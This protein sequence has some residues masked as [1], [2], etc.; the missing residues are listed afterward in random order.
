M[1]A[2]F[3]RHVLETAVL[4]AVSFSAWGQVAPPTAGTVQDTLPRRSPPQLE[5]A[6]PV[7]EPAASRQRADD[8]GP[9]VTVK[10][11]TISGETAFDE[12][13]LQAELADLIGKPLTMNDIFAAADRLTAYYRARGYGLASVV[14]PAQ[15]VAGGVVNLE[16][17]E[18]R[19]GQV[20]VEGRHSYDFGR[21]EAYSLQDE[22][23]LYRSAAMERTMLLLNDIPGLDARAIIQPG[24]KF[25]T[26]DV[27]LRV[28]EDRQEYRVTLDNYGREELGEVRL[29]G[30]ADFNNPFG[31]GDQLAVDLMY[32]QDGLLTYGSLAYNFPLASN[33]SRLAISANYA[34]YEVG[35]GDF[36]LLDISGDT[37]NF[38]VDYSYPWLRS[39]SNNL[40]LTAGVSR[41]AAETL[42]FNNAIPF[43]ETEL[44]LLEAGLF[45][46]TIYANNS[47]LSV[48]TLFSGNFKSREP[49]AADPQTDAQKAKLR[50]DASYTLPFGR[51][52]FTSRAA[53]VYSPDPLV[54]TQKYSLG[55]PF[56]VRG[57]AP[58]QVRGDK[59]LELSLEL[60]RYFPLWTGA[61]GAASVFVDG[62]TVSRYPAIAAVADDK[63]SL[64]SA[65]LGFR[66]DTNSWYKFTVY[67]ATPIGN[68]VNPLDPTLDFDDQFWLVANATF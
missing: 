2:S 32:T 45:W 65:G 47:S 64:A 46:N 38:R 20:R 35:G 63:D 18:G 48:F 43:N 58:A 39:R 16:V 52:A 8:D 67:W 50:V 36:A 59:G 30:E 29:L 10:R 11:F 15:R 6:P 1:S 66:V 28:N 14:V 24:A 37:S 26:S 61:R 68:H 25:G 44:T 56:S 12:A 9:T 19:I 40:L 42:I 62:G 4:A 5:S 21:L 7:A 49:T 17:I 41:N 60:Q 31:I 23:D 13:T 54:D 51:W 55:G 53:A 57:Y 3:F 34:D 27:V 33:G 22:G